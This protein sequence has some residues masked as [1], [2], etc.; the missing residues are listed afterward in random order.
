[1][2]DPLASRPSKDVALYGILASPMEE[3]F[4]G[5]SSHRDLLSSGGYSSFSDM[6]HYDEYLT[7][8]NGDSVAFLPIDFLE[9]SL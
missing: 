1:M 2:E 3:P 9:E 5:I 8:D 6:M 7:I 4:E